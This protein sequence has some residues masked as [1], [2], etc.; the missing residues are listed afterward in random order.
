MQSPHEQLHFLRYPVSAEY[1]EFISKHEQEL[2]KYHNKNKNNTIMV[3][4]ASKSGSSMLGGRGKEAEQKST[5][6]VEQDIQDHGENLVAGVIG[7]TGEVVDETG[8]T[9]GKVTE[10]EAGELVGNVVTA[11]GDI[12][13]K[14]GGVI[15]KALP[16]GELTEGGESKEGGG[17]FSIMGA[18]KGVKGIVD[19]VDGT[20]QTVNR[21]LP[22]VGDL[23]RGIGLGEG[24]GG[25][26]GGVLGGG[27]DEKGSQGGLLG[28]I[29]G[30]LGGGQSEKGGSEQNPLGSLLGGV[31][32]Q[33]QSGGPLGVLGGNEPLERDQS[34]TDKDEKLTEMLAQQKSEAG[35][36]ASVTENAKQNL[37]EVNDTTSE[38][39]PI[40]LKD[41]EKSQADDGKPTTGGENTQTDTE[42]S[43]GDKTDLTE[44]STTDGKD[45]L[46]EVDAEPIDEQTEGAETAK[47]D[48]TEKAGTVPDDIA[49]LDVPVSQIPDDLKSELPEDLQTADIP[50]SQIPFDAQSKLPTDLAS[51]LPSDLGSGIPEEG[52]E[53]KSGTE[54]PKDTTTEDWANQQNPANQS[55]VPEDAQ[56]G[57]FPK[58]EGVEDAVEG[59]EDAAEGVEDAAEDAK[60]GDVPD[61]DVTAAS[62]SAPKSTVKDDIKSVLSTVR[63]AI[64]EDQRT[65][66]VAGDKL[67]Q[68]FEKFPGAEI[69]D[70]GKV[71]FDNASIGRIAEGDPADLV[72]MTIDAEGNVINERGSIVGKAELKSEVA[73]ELLKDTIDFS[74][75]KGAKVNKAGN[76]INDKGEAVG[77][78]VSGILKHL[79]GRKADERGEIW[80]DAGKVIGKAEPIPETEREELAEPAPFEDFPGATVESNGHVL[81]N[82]DIVGRVIEGDAKKLKGKKVDEEGDILDKSGNAIGKAER[83][84][85]ESEPEPE[86][87]APVV[88][89]NSALAGKRVN[90]AGNVVDKDG[91]IYGRIVEGDVKKLIGRMCDKEGN[92]RSESGDIIGRAELIPESDREGAKEGPFAELPGCTVA[93]DGTIVTPSGDIVGRLVQGDAKTLFG[94]PIDE[95]GDILDRNGNLLGKAERWEPEAAPER[96]KGPMEGRKVNRSGEVVDADGDVIGKLT[97]GEVKACAG[98]IIN[99]DNDVVDSKGRIVGHVELLED[100]PEPKGPLEGKTVNKKGEV[101]SDSGELIGKLTTGD[102]S[103]CAGKKINEDNDV[104][105]SK[106]RVVGHV[107]LLEDLPEKKG[108]MEGRRV[109]R[110]GE[111]VD[112]DGNVIGKLTTGEVSICS[113]KEINSD[114]DVVDSKDR[115]VGHVSLL[116]DIP[117]PEVEEEEEVETE[118]QKKAREEAEADAKLAKSL[119]GLIE[120]G[121]DRLRPIC[122]MIT[123]KIEAAERKPKEERDEEQLVKDVK[124][125]IEEGGK[126]LTELNGSVRALDPDG[127]IQQNA[128]AKAQTREATPEEHHLAEVLKEL[129]GT[130][131]ETVEGAKRKIE[132]MPHAKSELNPLWGLLTEPLF[133][134]LAAV[135]LLLTGV[136]NLVGRL[137][138]GLGLGK[139]VDGLLGTLGLNRL[140][141]GL[142]LG[143][144][145]AALGGKKKK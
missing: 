114:N 124:P 70:E 108:P 82:G 121:L 78:I 10:G 40:D 104:V 15:G 118:E 94:R 11:T 72:G 99:E 55:Q 19:T 132:D 141:D 112:E 50:V 143:S 144:L 54:T 120:Q 119:G 30:A 145:T 39:A 98:K 129:T 51:K 42:D 13:G 76:L 37:F 71:I 111:V 138:N 46:Q 33:S 45:D 66:T 80:N 57:E 81:Y 140:L 32:G 73:D 68:P 85:P 58:T 9:V 43:Q 91:T 102:I 116:E 59:A 87:E 101:V 7:K 6:S 60:T 63:S 105:D 79:V 75:L 52:E 103:V 84:E 83:W 12:I 133:Q 17:G 142:G 56:T 20:V 49:T 136:L 8:K 93:K 31:L 95:D 123:Q 128:K 107:T 65:V 26:L 53:A 90:K 28:G 44:Q 131:T 109:N 47:D 134:I 127:R 29:T 122:K 69:D 3:G 86:P 97:S 74:I 35:D 62:D 115:V 5:Y 23:T 135:G 27:Q 34:V 61:I 41:A 77:R 130:I 100:I 4:A 125:L 25:V 1:N 38:V 64:P 18:T 139:I 92:V 89:D 88:V 126:I 137:L 110:Q 36:K 106:D 96:E 113:G 16:L 22:L 24:Q 67:L 48:A 14:D 21:T 2:Q 117:E